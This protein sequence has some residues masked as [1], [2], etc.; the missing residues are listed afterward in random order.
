[1]GLIHFILNLAAL[2]LWV[3]WRLL[4]TS[5]TPQR[6]AAA[7]AS[8]RK[9][10]ATATRRQ[11]LGGLIFLLGI[12]AVFY[13]QLGPAAS[14]TPK[15][16]LGALTLSFRGDFFGRMLLFSLLSFGCV[17]GVFYLSLLLLGMLNRCLT[18]A[19]LWHKRV[20]QQLGWISRCPCSLQIFLPLLAGALLWTASSQLL[21][22]LAIIPAP[23]SMAHLW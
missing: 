3:R 10:S 2:L 19:N 21:V 23:K 9:K 11:L 8:A 15:L 5:T 7:G 13:W 4:R 18:E 17:L 20:T 12:R 22:W 1:M 14:W 6:L 16:S